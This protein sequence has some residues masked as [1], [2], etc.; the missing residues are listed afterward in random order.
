MRVFIYFKCCVSIY[1]VPVLFPRLLQWQP[2]YK[3]S[4][5]SRFRFK[6]QVAGMLFND[7]G[8]SDR[9]ALAGSFA[10][11]FRCKKRL[12]YPVPDF[13]WNARA[14]VAY[15]HLGP[16][17]LPPRA[18]SDDSLMLPVADG[19][20]GDGMRRVDQQVQDNLVKFPDENRHVRQ[21]GIKF[22]N[23]FCYV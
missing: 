12:K 18:H 3:T 1:P 6:S 20:L 23:H 5:F 10:D 8:V 15:A 17:T 14:V 16:I 13:F 22:R 2:D 11:L 9:Q 7:D 21:A 4:P 19:R